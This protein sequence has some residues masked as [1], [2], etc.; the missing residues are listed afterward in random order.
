M[1]RTPS[2]N[3]TKYDDAT[4]LPIILLTFWVQKSDDQ[5]LFGT[6]IISTGGTISWDE[7]HGIQERKDKLNAGTRKCHH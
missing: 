6:A 3:A 7:W 5:V 2:Y 1:E 4:G